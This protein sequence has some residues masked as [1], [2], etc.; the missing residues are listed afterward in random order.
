MGRRFWVGSYARLGGEGLYPIDLAEDG[1]LRRGPPVAQLP[2]ASFAVLSP[3]RP[4]AWFVDERA[5]GQ[6]AAARYTGQGWEVLGAVPS[7]GDLPCYL[8]LHPDGDLLA[9]ANYADGA[10][11]LLAVDPAQ[12]KLTGP[13]AVTRGTGRGHD[14][15]RQD[16]PHAHC[17]VFSHDGAWL[18]HVDLGLD[19]IRRYAVVRNDARSASLGAPEVV[20]RAP[21]GWGA[22][23]LCFLPDG[24]HALLVCELAAR[25]ILLHLG[26][27][28]FTALTNVAMAAAQ[29]GGGKP[30]LGGSV[31]LLFADRALVT[32]RG[33][34]TVAML[35]CDGNALH[36]L[37]ERPSGGASPRHVL[38]VGHRILVANEEGGTLVSMPLPGQPDAPVHSLSI[39][40]AAFVLPEPVLS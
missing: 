2:N 16:G 18:F 37:A 20:F 11:A 21:E 24:A 35:A 4:L 1:A 6:V 3:G 33:A 5:G 17:V 14:P 9:V 13:L 10:V 39:P 23:H 26:D 22:R 40:G 8:A 32:N 27:G 36:R 28:A 29:G 19:Q 12:G 31:C 7:G 34:D 30:N 25:C 15:K 38:P